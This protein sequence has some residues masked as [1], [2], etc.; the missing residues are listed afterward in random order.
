MK[1]IWS[2]SLGLALIAVAISAPAPARADAPSLTQLRGQLDALRTNRPEN[3]PTA[4]LEGIAYMLDTV[5]RITTRFPAQ[6]DAWR[7]RANQFITR[8]RAGHDPYPE[9]RGKISNRGYMSPI[10]ERRQGYTVYIPPQY[11]P[12]RSYPVMVMLHGGSSNGNLFLGVTLGNNMSWL[13]YDQHLWDE[14]SPQWSPDWI[15]VAPDGYGQVLWRWMGEQDVL[16]VLAD[17]KAN[18]NVDNDRVVLC[19]LSNGGIGAHNIGLRHASLFSAVI[20]MAGAPSW[21]QYSGGRPRAEERAVMATLS[22]MHLLE[23]SYDTDYRYYHGSRDPGPM[24]PAFIEEL[25]RRVEAG[26]FPA[27][28]TWFDAGHDL[29]Y[30]VHRH[31]AIYDSLANVRRNPRPSSVHI[32]TGDYRAA[33]QFWVT[34]T[35][36]ANY[37]EIARLQADVAGD[38]ISV[39]TTG[40]EAFAIDLR[41]VPLAA[42]TH[43]RIVVD[44]REVFSGERASLGHVIHLARQARGWTTGYPETA[45]GL[46]KV[47]G[48]A[49]PLSDAYYGRMIHVYGTAN[50]EH[51]EALRR[52]AQKGSRGWPLWTWSVAQR[53]VADTEVNEEMMANATLVLYGTANDNAVLN[54]MSSRLPI[55]ADETGISFGAQRFEGNDIGVRYIY[56]NPL[57]PRSYVIVQTGVTPEAVMAGHNLPDF[58]GDYAIYDGAATRVRQ[59]LIFHPSAPRA[60]GFFDAHW[61]LPG[62]FAETTRTASADAIGE[63]GDDGPTS[64]SLATAY[65]LD[66]DGNPVT[67]L[68]PIPTAPPVPARP[69][70]FLAPSHDPAG[71]IARV[72]ARRVATFENYRAQIPGSTWNIDEGS[73]WSFRRQRDCLSALREANIRFTPVDEVPTT[74]VATPVRIDRVVDGV[75]FHH[76]HPE[77]P[78]ILACEMAAR[79]P[80]LLAVLHRHNIRRVDVLSSYRDHPRPSFHT[81]GLALDLANF[82]KS[83]SVLS[84]ENEFVV[85]PAQETCAGP[86]PTDAHA[87]ELLQIAC[88]LSESHA[89]STVLTPNYN[90]GHRNHFHID[91]R[92]DDP[93]LF[94]R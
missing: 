41:D 53:V 54:R 10:S 4:A 39:T 58:L 46:A 86:P 75:V 71:V 63:G 56:P 89:F 51:T 82:Y 73:V 21:E 78:V 65:P 43:A 80:I 49:G 30:I 48:L 32:A 28:G 44:G 27:R 13:E 50:A 18:Y 67:P 42:G 70:D 52:A 64:T 57:S 83:D 87:A 91:S 85:T 79:L 45:N 3:V 72:I 9:Q 22:G 59:R 81:L 68:M 62:A 1:Q 93:R 31:G 55:R 88:E 40:A 20:A 11:D 19:G 6:A 76:M 74:P 37:P 15:V 33:Q 5:E 77:Q 7:T 47:P 61:Q 12:T 17:V 23:N 26:H 38:T 2:Y 8:A 84:V 35:R 66:F 36:I 94:L 16:D 90:A 69:T 25:D 14:F 92:P 29:L 34:V 24:R 60:S